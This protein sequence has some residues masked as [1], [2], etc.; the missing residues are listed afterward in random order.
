MSDLWE[1]DTDE[2]REWVFANDPEK[3]YTY[4]WDVHPDGYEDFCWCRLCR[5]YVL[6]NG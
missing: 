4:D 2:F 5:S 1:G 3:A 6:E